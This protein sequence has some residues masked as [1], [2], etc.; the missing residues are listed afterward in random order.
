[1]L[2][3]PRIWPDLGSVRAEKVGGEWEQFTSSED[4]LA[5]HAGVLQIRLAGWAWPWLVQLD[6][7]PALDLAHPSRSLFA[8][9]W[10]LRGTIF[11][12]G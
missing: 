12:A 6:P 8:N 7:A 10:L 9:L 2:T 11:L 5:V 4:W 1:M 3:E